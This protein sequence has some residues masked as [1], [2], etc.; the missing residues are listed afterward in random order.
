[1]ASPYPPGH[2]VTFPLPLLLL[3]DLA[4]HASRPYPANSVLGV[5]RSLTMLPAEELALRHNPPPDY[6]FSTA[7]WRQAIDAYA[8]GMGVQGLGF[9]KY[10]VSNPE[11]FDHRVDMAVELQEVNWHQAI[12]AGLGVQGV[13]FYKCM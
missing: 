7:N 11:P 1:M 10:T 13:G 3:Q 4:V 9:Q 6:P 5:Y 2:L 8:A 12:D